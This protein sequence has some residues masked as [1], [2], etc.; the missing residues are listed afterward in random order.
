M[1]WCTNRMAAMLTLSS[2]CVLALT[3]GETL[4]EFLS[5]LN[6]LEQRKVLLI[7]DGLPTHRSR[8]MSAWGCEP[9]ALVSR[10]AIAGLRSRPQSDRTRLGRPQINGTC[11]LC[12][13]T[14]SEVA[15]IAEDGIDGKAVTRDFAW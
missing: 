7:W 12:S 2:N 5:D 4:I 6:E 9:T 14:I 10:G 3:N 15:D 1:P 8:R 11:Q 13:D